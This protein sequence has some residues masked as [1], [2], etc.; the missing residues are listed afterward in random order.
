MLLNEMA[1]FNMI[2]RVGYDSF[3]MKKKY[4]NEN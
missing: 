3:T 4:N 2:G 1:S